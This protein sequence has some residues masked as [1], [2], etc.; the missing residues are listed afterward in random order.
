M[1]LSEISLNYTDIT[2]SLV[3]DAKVIQG[4]IAYN[5]LHEICVYRN[6]ALHHDRWEWDPC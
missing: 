6:F 4:Y 1:E 2:H 3:I 5:R